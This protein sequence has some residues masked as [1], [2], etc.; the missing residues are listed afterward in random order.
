MKTNKIMHRTLGQFQVKQRTKDGFFNAT[1]LLKQ[2]NQAYPEDQRRIDNFWYSTNLEK[3]MAEI[4]KDPDNGLDF[5]SSDLGDLKKQLSVT[6]RGKHGGGTWMQPYLFTKFAMYLN[7]KFEYQ[8]VRF[9]TDQLLAYRKS[10]GDGYNQMCRALARLNAT[11]EDY[12]QVARAC[13]WIV[14]NKHDAELRQHSSEGQL[15]KLDEIQKKIAFMVEMGYAR[16]MDQL[17][18]QLRKLYH[19]THPAGYMQTP[20][21]QLR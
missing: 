20:G 8:V 9:I 12:M 5:K 13:N 2:W 1:D 15:K 3:Y 17:L 6:S 7:P 14:Y 4:V 10:A 16:N 11:Q 18:N 19:R 21:L